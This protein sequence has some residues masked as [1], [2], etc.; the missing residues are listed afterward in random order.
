MEINPTADLATHK[1]KFYHSFLARIDPYIDPSNSPNWPLLALLRFLLAFVVFASHV[2]EHT[3]S[4]GPLSAIS[5]LGAFEAI[6]GFLLISGYSI[7]MSITKSRSGYLLRRVKRIYPVYIACLILTF[8]VSPLPVTAGFVGMLCLNV[9]FLN[10]VVVPTSY[11]GPA[12]TLALEVWLYILAPSLLRF[13]YRTLLYLVYFSFACFCLYTCA[14]SLF[15]L[16]YYA[17]TYFGINL[18]LLSFIWILGFM[19]AIFH[20]KKKATTFHILFVVGMYFG[21]NALIQLAFRLKNGAYNLIPDD[22]L[23]FLTRGICLAIICYFIINQRKFTIRSSSVKSLFNFLGNISYPLYL[24]HAAF[25]VLFIR[26]GISN[27]FLLSLYSLVG[28]AVFYWLFDSFYRRQTTLP[29]T[30]N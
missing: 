27:W 19:L 29:S 2:G 9:V 3:A 30:Q 18:L 20:K 13:S 26:F 14:R 17:G 11:V 12:W 8:L 15:N 22:C 1:P 16:P 7:G 5:T 24:S 6:L 23:D 21:L 25:L 4:S 10:H 28:A